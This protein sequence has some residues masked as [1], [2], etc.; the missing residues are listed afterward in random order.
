M[1]GKHILG[2]L[3]VC[4][5]LGVLYYFVRP[6]PYTE[7]ELV[8]VF[9]QLSRKLDLASVGEVT[10]KATNEGEEVQVVLKKQEGKWVLP[11]LYNYPA[12][13][14]DA[15]DLI[16]D[17]LDMGEE[18][19]VALS[20]ESHPAYEVDAEKGKRLLIKGIDG[21][22]ICS[23]WIGKSDSDDW[24]RCYVRLDDEDRVYSIRP[25]LSSKLKAWN[26][27][28]WSENW[29]D[30]K[31]LDLDEDKGEEVVRIEVARR[32][33]KGFVLE[34][35]VQQRPVEEKAS[36]ESS[37]G[38]SSTTSGT[39]EK[40][41][42]DKT[43]KS[44]TE[45]K[46][47]KKKESEKPK[48]IKETKWYVVTDEGRFEA[49]STARSSF[50]SAVSSVYGSEPVKPP[51]DLAD[52]G[53][54][55]AYL[56]IEITT[57]YTKE[58]YK[59]EKP[60]TYVLLI[61]D[62]VPEKKKEEE[63]KA[64]EEKKE[65]KKPEAGKQTESPKASP[66]KDKAEKGKAAPA[67]ETQTGKKEA[68]KTK[69]ASTSNTSSSSATAAESKKSPEKGT[70]GSKAGD[71]SKK[72][73]KG[74]KESTPPKEEKPKLTNNRYVHVKGDPRYMTLAE[75]KVKSL[76]KK[77]GDFKPKEKKTEKKKEE[78]KAETPAKSTSKAA[79]GAGKKTTA[80]KAPSSEKAS[81]G[82][83]ESGKAA[84]SP[85]AS[86][87]SPAKRLTAR[88]IL[89]AYKG[90][91]IKGVTRSK[92][93]ARKE[94]QKLLDKIK[95]GEATLEELAKKYS[96]DART[97]QAGGLLEDFK[98]EDMAKPFREAV[99]KLKPGQISDVVE[100]PSGFYIIQRVK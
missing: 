90:S 73:E 61:G 31:L 22:E 38:S 18:R 29:L 72:E 24:R 83:S 47:S 27:K 46:E 93:E 79:E 51:A 9:S 52:Y 77:P 37:E 64:T 4:A 11:T 17:L 69:P 43:Q 26:L 56:A 19:L 21:K 67:G 36:S 99:L 1:S 63:K 65:E 5:V 40:G 13:Q 100:T 50:V 55:P 76:D 54:D 39:A 49:D 70:E 25:N 16:L 78:K 71:A 34:K 23:L 75:W 48:T 94:A 33:G 98:P 2:A 81:A 88:H 53:L 20:P 8:D 6:T 10:L 68:E 74:K 66:G 41:A 92:E 96:D 60:K 84:A 95:K 42:A 85:K 87:Q 44:G 30:K 45:K 86:A 59:K 57:E 89:I 32:D 28:K 62:R 7:P 3:I 97:R 15:D 91:G 14:K 82:K 58:E 35:I 80:K 12:N